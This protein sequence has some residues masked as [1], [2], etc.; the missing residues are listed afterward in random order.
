MSSPQ[1]AFAGDNALESWRPFLLDAARE[2]FS[3]MVGM[4]LVVPDQVESETG[5]GI[6]GMV[7]LAGAI[8]GVL[9]ICSNESFAAETASRMLGLS[10]EEAA[11]HG[12]DAMGEICNMIAGSF[13]AKIGLE[14]KCMLSVPTVITG[15][16]YATHSLIVGNHLEAQLLFQGQPLTITLETRS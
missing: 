6:T 1:Q 7:G 4:E 13:K 14:D 3:V 8:C 5:G 10:R 16:S 15:D 2:V 9:T 12:S 11:L